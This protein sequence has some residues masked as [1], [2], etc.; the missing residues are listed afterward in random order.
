MWLQ[1]KITV[2]LGYLEIGGVLLTAK[3]QRESCGPIPEASPLWSEHRYKSAKA[4]HKSRHPCRYSSPAYQRHQKQNR[5]KQINERI[6][7]L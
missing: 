7:L 6:P 3:D 5:L 1:S 4:F 2:A